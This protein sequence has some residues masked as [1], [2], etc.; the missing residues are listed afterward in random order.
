MAFDFPNAPIV[1]QVFQGWTWDGEKWTSGTGFGSIYVSDTAPNA[2]VNS[3]WWQ[4]S[5]GILYVRYAD[6]TSTQW[7]AM[8]SGAAPP[9]PRKNYIINGAM[10]VSQENAGPVTAASSYPVDQFM[11]Q[12]ANAGT[13]TAQ[14]VLGFT[15]S[16]SP[17]RLRVTATVA[18]ASVAATD[19]LYVR[20]AVEGLRVAD[21]KIGTASAK[22]VTFQFGIKAPAGTYCVALYNGAANRSY[23][24]EVVV[25]SGEANTDV[26]KSV[27]L[28][29]DTAGTWVTDNTA[30]LYIQITLMCGTT[31]QTAANT[32]TAGTFFATSN[33]FNFMGTN[34]NV[35][36]LFDVSLTE[37]NV[38]PPF[39][40]P[41]YASELA[42]CQRYWCATN[43]ATPKGGTVGSIGFTVGQVVG[44]ISFTAV[45]PVTMRA[46]PTATL[47]NSGVQNTIRRAQDSQIVTFTTPSIFTNSS[48]A[49]LLAGATSPTLV[50]A[51]SYDFD[52]IAN[53]RL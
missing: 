15:P 47:W 12:F 51:T 46:T 22:Q 6:G 38:A 20:Q 1:G 7:V 11:L 45:W 21:L 9:A 23:V 50:A 4:S 16:G 36:E 17:N 35:F 34:G 30:G 3:L 29:L 52:L 37:G 8:A 26:V 33:Q 44:S 49:S 40:V 53:A 2:P 41:D 27:T 32:W 39:V 43:P 18:D 19:N 31:Y 5:T 25:A 48:G 28:T 13:Q 42:A 24:S 10:M 14:Q